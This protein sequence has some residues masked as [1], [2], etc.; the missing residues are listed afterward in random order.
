MQLKKKKYTDT[1]LWSQIFS[2]MVSSCSTSAPR[3]AHVLLPFSSALA[4]ALTGVILLW[5]GF[6]PS[7]HG[8][9]LK[10]PLLAQFTFAT[11]L[12]GDSWGWVSIPTTDAPPSPGVPYWALQDTILRPPSLQWYERALY[13]C[14]SPLN[15][16]HI[17]CHRN[18]LHKNPPSISEVCA[19]R[20]GLS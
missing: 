6:P 9:C 17:S 14:S 5:D 16:E 2:T 4:C 7:W 19:T 20:P 1:S 13:R 15:S 8:W 18:P 11:S 12:I 3:S 10:C